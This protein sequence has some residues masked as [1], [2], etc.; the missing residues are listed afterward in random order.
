MEINRHLRRMH[1]EI[2]GEIE[3]QIAELGGEVTRDPATD[4]LQVNREFRVSVVLAR[5]HQLSENH[6]RWKIRMD[7]GLSP[8]ISVAAR[9]DHANKELLDY[10]LLPSI[11][12]GLSRISLADR[13]PIELESY[14]FDSLDFFYGMAA[15][16]KLRMAA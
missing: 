12:F 3:R 9:L 11:D 1:P 10:Y 2:V 14:R 15:R 8:D 5:A 13:N 6:C 7:R 16:S 4:L